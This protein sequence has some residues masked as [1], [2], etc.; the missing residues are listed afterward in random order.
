MSIQKVESRVGA[1][2]VEVGTCYSKPT[3]TSTLSFC[4]ALGR[5]RYGPQSESEMQQSDRGASDFEVCLEPQAALALSGSGTDSQGDFKTTLKLE[6]KTPSALIAR[7]DAKRMQGNFEGAIA[8]LHLALQLEPKK[9]M[10]WLLSC[11]E[12]PK[13]YKESILKLLRT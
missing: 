7:A 4:L 13:D 2:A 12:I 10:S 5:Q 3:F 9:K 8:D 1:I 11:E 6:P